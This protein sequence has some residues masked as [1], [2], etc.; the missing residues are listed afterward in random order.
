MSRMV[1]QLNAQPMRIVDHARVEDSDEH[2]VW[3]ME[4]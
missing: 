2:T 4:L 3:R 1:G